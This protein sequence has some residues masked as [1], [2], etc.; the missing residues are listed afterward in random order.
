MTSQRTVRTQF[1]NAA[2]L[3]SAGR[4]PSGSGCWAFQVSRS[5]SAFE[6]DL[7]GEVFFAPFGTL[8]EAKK[9]AAV[10]FPGKLVAVM[11]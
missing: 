4:K 7:S 6:A 10:R 8:T 11:P 9:A 3:R 5:E 1:T 2:F